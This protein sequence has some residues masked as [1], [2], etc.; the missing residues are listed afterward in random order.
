LALISSETREIIPLMKE[1]VT[2]LIVDDSIVD[3]NLLE[4]YIQTIPSLQLLGVYAQPLEAIKVINEQKPQLLFSDIEMPG[5]TGIQL[6]KALQYKPL[7]V[8]L[9]NHKEYGAETYDA[10]A[11]SY[12]IKPIQLDKFTSVANKAIQKLQQN[13]V[14]EQDIF[15]VR[16]DNQFIPLNKSQITYV[17]AEDKFVKIHL[18]NKNM[19]TVWISLKALME[20]LNDKRFVRIH[21]SFIV[22]TAH[23]QSI[24]NTE[25]KVADKSLPLS[26]QH[27]HELMDEYVKKLLIKK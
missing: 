15:I 19:H 3:G 1:M 16:T 11:F 23:I 21:R 20:Q 12:L 5:C 8:F 4:R 2:C 26:D 14:T 10:E 24:G 9:S 13:N 7:T 6:L 17:E 22:N 18:L 27:K 25:V